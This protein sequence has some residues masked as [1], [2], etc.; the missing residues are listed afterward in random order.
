MAKNDVTAAINI[1]FD[2][3]QKFKPTR[4]TNPQP[5]S[6]SPPK[7]TPS[8][9]SPTVTVNLKGS[10]GEGQSDDNSDD[11][12]F[13]GCGEMTGLSTCKGRTISSGE[14]V[15]FRFPTK[16]PAAS[17]PKGLG[18]AVICSEIVRFS[19]EQAGEVMYSDVV[20]ELMFVQFKLCFD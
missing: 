8:T 10:G 18:R 9:P 17:S 3:P 14:T 15:V 6:V 16:T 12:W 7:P 2:T 19:T 11:L 4:P 5:V 20:T 13:V 1:I